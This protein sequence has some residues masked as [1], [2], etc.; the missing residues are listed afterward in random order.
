[1]ISHPDRHTEKFQPQTNEKNPCPWDNFKQDPLP[2][3]HVSPAD[4]RQRSCMDMEY[5]RFEVQYRQM[6]DSIGEVAA[7]LRETPEVAAANRV[8]RDRM[9]GR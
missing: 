9:F 7:L 2:I 5:L 3:L 8:V 1:M 4:I 6:E